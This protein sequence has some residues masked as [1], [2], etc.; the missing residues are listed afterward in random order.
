M[1]SWKEMLA[2]WSSLGSQLLQ[3]LL[4]PPHLHLLLIILWQSWQFLNQTWKMTY[5]CKV[6][7]LTVGLI[8]SVDLQFS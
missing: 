4:Q 6:I 3:W 1:T 7:A 5:K 2:T 8:D